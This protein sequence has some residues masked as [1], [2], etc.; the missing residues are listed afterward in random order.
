M[1]RLIYA[2]RRRKLDST[3]GLISIVSVALMFKSSS[4]PLVESLSGTWL[5]PVLLQYQTG[6]QIVFD[7]AVGI[8]VSIFFYVLVVRVP[9]A[10]KRGR[11]RKALRAQ[12]QLLKE[13]CIKNFLFACNGSA[14]MS[15]VEKLKDRA[16]F[17]SYF[18]E[19]VTKSQDRWHTVLNGLDEQKIQDILIELEVFRHEVEY[20]L[21]SVD[22]RSDEAFAFLKQLTQVLYR[23]KSWTHNYDDVKQL[24][25]FMWAIHTGWSLVYGYIDRD[26]IAEMIEAA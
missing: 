23:S 19:P 16:H 13:A 11:L 7:V 12:Y 2:L 22:V 8:V 25:Q 4:D 26:A 20:V 18:S 5:E 24:S 10:Q 15:L 3:L 1:K 9:E 21:S 14:D 6:N 17:K